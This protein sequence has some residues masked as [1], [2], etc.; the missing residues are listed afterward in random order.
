[1]LDRINP[2]YSKLNKIE[3]KLI[4][5]QTISDTIRV[6]RA[7]IVGTM[8]LTDANRYAKRFYRRMKKDR[9]RAIDIRY[10][11]LTG[12]R[13]GEDGSYIDV[14][15]LDAE[16]GTLQSERVPFDEPQSYP[17]SDQ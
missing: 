9:R 6:A 5:E 15:Q 17:P 16:I 3:Q 7:S 14:F 1:M 10:K 2:Q 13:F 12:K 8:Q 4:M 11:E